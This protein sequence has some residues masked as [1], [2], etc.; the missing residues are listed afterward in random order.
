MPIK[1]FTKYTNV[2]VET[3]S[4][5]GKGIQKALDA[6]YERVISIE[7]QEKYYLYCAKRFLGDERV[8]LIHGDSS[9]LL[10]SIISTVNEPITFWLDGHFSE[11]DKKEGV[12]LKYLSPLIQELQAIGGHHIKNHVILIDDVRCWDGYENIFHS[13][14]NTDTLKDELRKINPDYDIQY[15][16]G[17]QEDGSVM[18]KDIMIAL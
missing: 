9:E 7:F 5:L 12:K 15:M 1:S 18:V 3:G 17:Q 6:G 14:F 4:H 2:F 8:I 13:G 10:P 16:D 11:N